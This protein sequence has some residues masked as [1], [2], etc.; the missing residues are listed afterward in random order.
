MFSKKL[1]NIEVSVIKQM[2]LAARKY[3]NVISLAQGIPTFD[4]PDHIKNRDKE[5]MD[6]GVTARYSIVYGIAPLREA[7]AEKLRKEQNIFIDQDRE[8]VITVGAAEALASTFIS[9][10]DP[11]D[12]VIIVAPSYASYTEMI[13]IAGGKPVEAELDEANAWRLSVENIKKK[14]TDKTKAVLMCNPNNPTGTIYS[15]DDLLA[16]GRW[17][18]EKGI[19][20]II[21]EVYRDFLYDINT[22]YYSLAEEQELKDTV[23]RIFS[24]SKLF[25]M[26]GWRVGYITS[27]AENISQIIKAHDSLVT[28]APVISQYAALASLSITQV[29]I[30]EHMLEYAKRREVMCSRLDKMKEVFSYYKPDS[31]YFVLVKL[32]KDERLSK[33]VCLDILDKTQVATVPGSAFGEVGEGHIR[34][35]YGETPERIEEAFDRLEKYFKF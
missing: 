17:A 13:K 27:S 18:Q 21:D 32:L 23:I 7:I 9:L 8:I 11:G 31:T 20:I 30:D 1:D 6:R 26:T 10:C 24:F 35:M 28:C 34:M 2:E 29:E 22:E 12:E 25:A 15:K 33:E 16:V 5:F 4:T 3:D 14:Y 19:Y